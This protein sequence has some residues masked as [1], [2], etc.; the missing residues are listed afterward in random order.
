[1]SG[2]EKLSY[3]GGSVHAMGEDRLLALAARRPWAM[4]G[5]ELV[6]AVD[7]AHGLVVEAQSLLLRLLRQVDVQKRAS[8][9]SAS[10]AAVWYR[11]RHRVGIGGAHRLVRIAKR[12]AAAPEVL[13]EAVACG[14]VNMDQADVITYAL[15]RIPREVGVDI[16]EQAAATLVKLCAEFDPDQLKQIGARILSMVAPEVADEVDRKAMERE[17]AQAL[18]ERYFTLTSDGVGVRL[19]GRLT[20]EGAAVVRAAIDPLCTPTSHDGRSLEQRRADALVD[21]CKLALATTDLPENG[22]TGP[23]SWWASTSTSSSSNSGSARW[24]TATGS[25]R[26][27]PVEWP[28]TPV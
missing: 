2:T 14:A 20:P 13:G 26:R 1:L 6:T 28:A 10:S 12:V 24:T 27:P 7:Q 21:V 5:P 19:S 23:G 8:A 22:G 18:R 16:R 15:A 3:P 4:S 9:A 17:E 25:L 11:N